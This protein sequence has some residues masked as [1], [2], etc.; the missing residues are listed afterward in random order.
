MAKKTIGGYEVMYY[1]NTT[2]LQGQELEQRKSSC[3]KDAQKVLYLF[4]TKLSLTAWE[5]FREFQQTF[6]THHIQKIA[7]AARIKDLTKA[8]VLYKSTE[9]VRDLETGA[10]NNK[11]KLFP[12]Q[13][14]PDDFDMNTLEI[15][16]VP[17][18]FGSDGRPDADQ[19]RLEFERKLQTKISEYN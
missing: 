12:Y 6:P 4:E 11:Y 16:K 5:A 7:V 3:E 8:G 17:L 9:Q 1:H 14:F 18:K 13:G 2:N 19:T 15:I 10:I